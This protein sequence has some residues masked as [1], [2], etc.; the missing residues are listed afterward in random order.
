MNNGS[1]K[2]YM[3]EY[4]LR[5]RERILAQKKRYYVRNRERIRAS[6]R[7]W[8][9]KNT[10][11]LSDSYV[12]HRLRNGSSLLRQ[13]FPSEIV[14]IK[15][16]QLKLLRASRPQSPKPKPGVQNGNTVATEFSYLA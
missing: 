14:E 11:S 12:R 6:Q 4:Y 1:E 7:L 2:A 13:D 3:A 5:N 10:D 15:R 16:L 9:K 8:Q